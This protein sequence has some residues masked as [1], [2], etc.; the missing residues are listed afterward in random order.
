MF[1]KST[2]THV[3]P[4]SAV[5][6]HMFEKQTIGWAYRLSRQ[7]HECF[8]SGFLV[9]WQN[10]TLTRR[11]LLE[12]LKYSVPILTFPFHMTPSS[13]G[14]QLDE[15]REPHCARQ[16]RE[17]LCLYW[18]R[19]TYG[20]NTAHCRYQRQPERGAPVTWASR[21]VV[22]PAMWA[23]QLKVGLKWPTNR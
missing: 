21:V 13:K 23:L 20:S 16:R 17:A 2:L 18:S 4:K 10:T 22:T 3:W 15:L 11:T 12:I 7:R 6:S 9:K 19:Q 5:Q 8:S 14:G 1:I